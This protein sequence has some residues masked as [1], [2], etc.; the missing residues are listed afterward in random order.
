M[1]LTAA[2]ARPQHCQAKP[3]NGS[4]Q[5]GRPACRA[6]LWDAAARH[7]PGG[8]GSQWQFSG[9]RLFGQRFTSSSGPSTATGRARPH[10][11]DDDD[12]WRWRRRPWWWG[13][14]TRQRR[15]KRD[16]DGR[17]EFERRAR[18]T[19]AAAAAKVE[20][21]S[22]ASCKCQYLPGYSQLPNSAALCVLRAPPPPPPPLPFH[23]CNWQWKKK[24]EGLTLT[25]LLCWQ[26]AGEVSK[27]CLLLCLLFLLLRQL[28]PKWALSL[29]LLLL[30]CFA[31]LL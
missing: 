5:G 13:K 6:A 21:V 7:C 22:A 2:P 26:R 18:T 30:A 29:S 25:D 27:A 14:G 9:R 8:N 10:H 3:A 31:A 15:K 17:F 23:L 20:L 4:A 12:C 19:A 1:H 28:L 24:R 16:N 11:R